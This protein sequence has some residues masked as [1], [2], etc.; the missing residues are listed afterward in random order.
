[1]VLAASWL[2]WKQQAL[3]RWIALLGAVAG[4]LLIIG[5]ASPLESQAL[6][7]LFAVRGVSFLLLVVF[8]IACSL[9]LLVG[10]RTT[11]A[12]P[13]EKLETSASGSAE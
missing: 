6:G 4:V 10:Q 12:I 11:S 2:I 1:M 5:A 9:N 8:V 3:W 13:T 7:I